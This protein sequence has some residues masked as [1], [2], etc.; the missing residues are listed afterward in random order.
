MGEIIQSDRSIIPACDMTS[1]EEFKSLVE[2]T[3]DVPGIGGYKIGKLLAYWNSLPVVVK[4]AREF[5]DKPLIVDDQKFGNDIPDLGDKIMKM[6]SEAGA[7]A[8]ILFPFA[9]P[10]TQEA[11]T[12][13]AQKYEL[14][15]IV[16]GEMTHPEFLERDGGYLN[17]EAPDR[18]YDIA[19]Y[20][21]VTNFVVPGNK[22][23]AI[24]YY[25]G[26]LTAHKIDLVFY[27][28]GFVK[29]GG[30]ITDAAKAAGDKFHG[31]VGRAI[32]Q[33]EDKKAAAM[34][35]TSQLGGE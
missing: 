9:G 20:A 32:Y 30:K 34:E 25:R 23:K 31:I 35:M 24:E 21:G 17:N 11:W 28:P 12:K 14:G 7:D 19:A 15:V 18:I 4:A 10:K 1:L 13:A 27:S 16:G 33:A 5:T 22:P 3:H 8:V 6:V 2:Q 29:Q 26:I